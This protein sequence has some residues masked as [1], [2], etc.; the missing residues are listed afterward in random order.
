MLSLGPLVPE[1][2]HPALTGTEFVSP[3]SEEKR[4]QEEERIRHSLRE[5][6]CTM[7]CCVGMFVT[8]HSPACA[9]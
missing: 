5:A 1:A 6:S 4:E 9:D 8:E 2:Q 3:E 7:Q